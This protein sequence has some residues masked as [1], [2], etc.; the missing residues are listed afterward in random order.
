MRKLLFV[1]GLL[2]LLAGAATAQDVDMVGSWTVYRIDGLSNYTMVD[3]SA[4]RTAAGAEGTLLLQG[5]GNV[6]SEELGFDSWRMENGFF[7]L[8]DSGGNNFFV[9]RQIS[10]DV[11]FLVNLTVTER[12]REVTHIRINRP[13]NL[14]VVRE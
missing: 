2:I 4:G 8:Q 12:N 7:V 1:V 3:Y 13:Q 6:M 14:L 10:P 9:V 5:D 11:R